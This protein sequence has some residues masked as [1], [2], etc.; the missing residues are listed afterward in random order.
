MTRTQTRI[1]TNLAEVFL[2][3]MRTNW[4]EYSTQMTLIL[5]R[6]RHPE[7]N[8]EPRITLIFADSFV[9]RSGSAQAAG[10]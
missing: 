2:V 1:G 9:G 3:G 10:W 6:G 4:D 7:K 5:S 8:I